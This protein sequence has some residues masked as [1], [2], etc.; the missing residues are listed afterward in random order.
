[1]KY[2]EPGSLLT[3]TTQE[4]NSMPTPRTILLLTT[5]SAKLAEFK[6]ALG[7]HGVRV[8]QILSRDRAD[9]TRAQLVLVETTQLLNAQH[10]PLGEYRHLQPVINTSRLQVYGPGPAGG[11]IL[12]EYLVEVPGYLDLHRQPDADTFDWDYCFVHTSINNLSNDELRRAGS[13]FS[14]RQKAIGHFA[15]EFLKL[16]RRH[17]FNFTPLEQATTI[18]FEGPGAI[19]VLANNPYLAAAPPLIQALLAEVLG[20]GVFLRA[21]KNR[22]E[23]NYWLPGLN[24]GIPATPKKDSLHEITFLVHDLMH[25]LFADLILIR[26][27]PRDRAIYVVQRMMS[28]A[29]TLVLA[30]ML[31][32][33]GLAHADYPYDYEKRRIYPIYAEILQ[34]GEPELRDLLWASVQLCLAANQGP[35]LA[36]GVS[37]ETLARFREKYDAFFVRDYQWT[38][39]NAEILLQPRKLKAIGRWYDAMSPVIEQLQPRIRTTSEFKLETAEPSPDFFA[40]VL[41]CVFEEMFQTLET[42]LAKAPAAPAAEL[43]EQRAFRKY[44]VGQSFMYFELGEFYPQ[45]LP[46][47]GL[48]RQELLKASLSSGDMQRL[49][50]FYALGLQTLAEQNI[51]VN[52]DDLETYRELYPLF[53]PAYVS[54]DEPLEISLA[55]MVAGIR[56]SF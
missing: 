41:E 34:Q 52:Q 23:R 29:F 8:E 47:A 28:E 1:M 35:Y 17:Q 39:H 36:L 12:A 30:D 14:A 9:F 5:N 56:A 50:D 48:I 20:S 13:K 31:F 46:H 27:T 40:A 3:P 43:A 53:L 33:S 54:Y 15:A 37:P 16:P 11:V 22:R 42:A 55:E 32:V 26:D 51:L 18:S 10:Q 2:N 19:E 49:R 38:L 6:T 24:A 25:H 4:A 44:M 21:A 7:L 45:I